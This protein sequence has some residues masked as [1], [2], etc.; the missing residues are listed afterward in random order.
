MKFSDHGLLEVAMTAFNSIGLRMSNRRSLQ[1]DTK[2]SE[3]IFK[4]ALELGTQVGVDP[5]RKGLV[6]EDQ[7]EGA[8]GLRRR[9]VGEG[10]N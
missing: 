8:E 3:T 2:C 6:F 1:N 4:F 5:A 9:V 10:N 7:L